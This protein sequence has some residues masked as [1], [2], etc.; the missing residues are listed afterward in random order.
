MK[1]SS[2]LLAALALFISGIVVDRAY[3]GH[4]VTVPNIF[5]S[6]TTASAA[7]VNAN[8]AA[9]AAK[10]ATLEDQLLAA[11]DL[12]ALA[13]YLK[14]D[15]SGTYDT[16]LFSG[17][18][19]QVVNGTDD[20]TA[21]NGLGNLIVGYNNDRTVGSSACSDGQYDNSG[22]CGTGGETWTLSHKSGSHNIVAG[23]ENSYSQ[24]SG[25]VFGSNNLINREYA[26]VTGGW[27]NF[28][29]GYYSSVSGGRNNIAGGSWSSVSGGKDNIASGYYSSVSGGISNMAS[30]YISSVSGGQD[31]AASGSVSS[32]SGGIFNMASGYVSSVSGGQNNEASGNYSTSMGGNNNDT[33]ATDGLV[34]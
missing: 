15:E 10:I 9:L 17:V 3:S 12:L 4:S 21:L 13:P 34:P 22:D 6:G 29:S 1:K 32:V 8:F 23:D 33:A 14:L 5:S 20:Q 2:L 18:N 28:A 7:E 11:A 30:G 31:N 25:V 26:G 27:A 19:V 16:A 24:H